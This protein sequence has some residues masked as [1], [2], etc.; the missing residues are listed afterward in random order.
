MDLYVAASAWTRR[1]DTPSGVWASAPLSSGSLSTAPTRPR[2]SGLSVQP[3]SAQRRC[4][5]PMVA[6]S[7]TSSCFG[8][9]IAVSF[10]GS[11]VFYGLASL[12]RGSFFR[13]DGQQ[14]MP[15]QELNSFICLHH[16]HTDTIHFFWGGVNLWHH[17][18]QDATYMRR[19]YIQTHIQTNTDTHTRLMGRILEESFSSTV[20]SR[21]VYTR[22]CIEKI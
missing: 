9:I 17:V 13:D 4:K 7:H 8:H 16:M 20:A 6:V 14:L 15:Y 2:C 22:Y 5:Q 18:W 10:P 3:T 21:L 11:F 19:I 1:L 12:S